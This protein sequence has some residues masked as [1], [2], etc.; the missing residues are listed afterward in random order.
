MNFLGGTGRGALR[1][2]FAGKLRVQID[3]IF[4][5]GS[6]RRPLIRYAVGVPPSPP[7]KDFYVPGEESPSPGGVVLDKDCASVFSAITPSIFYGS[8]SS[9]V[10]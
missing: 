9:L 6:S 2:N 1:C 4:L 7:G 5:A 8:K 3:Q 10:G